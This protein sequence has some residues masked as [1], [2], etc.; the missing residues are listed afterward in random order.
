MKK[1]KITIQR[2]CPYAKQ[3]C[4]LPEGASCP[5]IPSRELGE[6]RLSEWAENA[7]RS[8]LSCDKAGLE[9]TNKGWVNR[10]ALITQQ[11]YEERVKN[12]V[13]TQLS[14]IQAH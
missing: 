12:E 4:L 5:S 7:K 1:L 6:M 11:V 8:A 9:L 13:E 2:V 14:K 3:E 10:Y